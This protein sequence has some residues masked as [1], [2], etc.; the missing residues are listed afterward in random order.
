MTQQTAFLDVN[1]GWA[2]GEDNWNIGM[3]DNLLKFSALLDR[4]INGI[5]S[6]LPAMDN[7]DMYF[8]TTDSKLYYNVNS[9]VRSVALPKGFVLTLRSNGDQYVF[10]GTSLVPAFDQEIGDQ[11]YVPLSATGSFG[12]TL[13]STATDAAARSSLGLGSAALQNSDSFEPAIPLDVYTSYWRGDKTWS[14][15]GSDVRSTA[16][17]GFSP[18][19]PTAVVSTDLLLPAMGKLQAQMNTKASTS[20]PSLS[21]TPTAPTATA[22]TNTTQI[23]TTAFVAAAVT[24]GVPVTSVAGKTGAVTLVKG[25]VGLDNVD[26]T[27]DSAKPVS[28]AQQ[29]AL[30]AKAPLASP[31][32]TGVPTAPT[33]TAG[34][35]TT[36]VATTAFVLANA[37]GSAIKLFQVQDQKAT[38]TNGGNPVATTWT[39]RTLNTSVI[40]QVAGAFLSSYTISLPAGD[41]YI[42][43]NV[44]FLQVTGFKAR[45]YNTTDS[46]TAIVGSSA[47]GTSNSSMYSAIRGRLSLSSPKNFVVQ[48]YASNTVS[49]GLGQP[50]NAAPEVE[51]YTSLSIWKLS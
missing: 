25:D 5:V 14:S 1:Y 33:A 23:A 30:N 20:S 40:N 42:D 48:Y 16:L 19:N 3:D 15:F 29:T 26:N 10:D 4:T 37:A 32:F 27:A 28:T 50:S 38:N 24:A 34:T 13:L 22:G 47:G 49:G 18:T 41:Y 31:A 21:G 9:I 39:T 46:T 7:G 12:M 6:T 36:Q 17:T 8:N 43:G 35:N 51:V 11:R 44:P 2:K 45:L